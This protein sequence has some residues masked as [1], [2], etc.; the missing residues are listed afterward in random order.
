MLCENIFCIYWSNKKCS[1]NHIS[2]DIQGRCE[3]CI[4]INI[5]EDTLKNQR[6]ELLNIYK[7]T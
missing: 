4:Y 5:D 7:K 6:K 1:L 2:L 3:N